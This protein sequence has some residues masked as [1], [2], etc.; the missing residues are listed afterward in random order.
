[1]SIT[2]ESECGTHCAP[3]RVAS[4]ESLL[5]TE[6]DINLFNLPSLWNR[7]FI[8]LILFM[9]LRFLMHLSGS[10]LSLLESILLSM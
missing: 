8:Y 5:D 4:F 9:C 3:G 7:S 2:Q 1:M 10:L 6:I